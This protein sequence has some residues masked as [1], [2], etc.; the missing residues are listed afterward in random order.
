MG[1]SNKR[2]TES[3]YDSTLYLPDLLS[4]LKNI[5]N[6]TIKCYRDPD[7]DIRPK[8]RRYGQGKMELSREYGWV[9]VG[10]IEDNEV[11][12]ASVRFCWASVDQS[13]PNCFRVDLDEEI[14]SLDPSEHTEVIDP[15]TER[16][17]FLVLYVSPSDEGME[18]N[19]IVSYIGDIT[20]IPNQRVWNSSPN[21]PVMIQGNGLDLGY[22]CRIAKTV[23][24]DGYVE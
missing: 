23:N 17:P 11:V 22:G 3:D 7:S 8:E 10:D 4:V 24:L 13:S 14:W 19:D 18:Y 21:V 9:W 12:D 15:T 1:I 6:K 20:N 2:P 5:P 16:S